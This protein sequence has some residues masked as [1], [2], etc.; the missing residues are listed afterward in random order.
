MTV[1]D[2]ARDHDIAEP[3]AWPAWL[4]DAVGIVLVMANAVIWPL[5]F[6]LV[7]P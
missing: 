3:R 2:G 5:F 1:F 7:V 4:L 6:Y